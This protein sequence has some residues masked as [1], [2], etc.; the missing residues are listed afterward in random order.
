MRKLICV[1]FVLISVFSLF[2]NAELF[3]Q[4]SSEVQ[5]LQ[6]LFRRAGLA[7]PELIYPVASDNLLKLMEYSD[8]KNKLETDDLKDYQVLYDRFNGNNLFTVNE[9]FKFDADVSVAPVA[10]YNYGKH[11]DNPMTDLI[12]GLNE[13]LPF[14]IGIAK[15]ELGKCF[16]GR[17]EYDYTKIFSKYYSDGFILNLPKGSRNMTGPYSTYLSVG[18]NV[19]NLFAGRVRASSGNGI[20]GN[21]AIGDNFIYR[22]TV[23]FGLYT[24][25]FVYELFINTFSN[26]PENSNSYFT[27]QLDASRPLVMIHKASYSILDNLSVGFYEGI[28]DYSTASPFD[29]RI[30]NPFVLFHNLITYHYSTNNFFGFETDFS[31]KNGHSFHSQVLF[32]QIN[33]GPGEDYKNEPNSF[34]ILFNYQ[35]AARLNENPFIG[36][37]EFAYTNPWLYMKTEKFPYGTV[38]N[39][40]Y[41]DLDLMVGNFHTNNEFDAN[42]IGYKFG[43]NTLAFDLGAEYEIKNNKLGAD[44]LLKFSGDTG[45]YGID[46]AIGD[47]ERT[48]KAVSPFCYVT[49]HENQCLIQLKLSDEATLFDNALSVNLTVGLQ[50]YINYGCVKGDNPFNVQFSLGAKVDPLKIIERVKI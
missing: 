43:P 2:A 23:K 31:L 10:Y 24:F 9:M 37:F 34:G 29:P 39:Y 25:P 40:D 4:S 28:L 48:R 12:V 36:Y 7:M 46:Y 15:L 3:E 14:L 38:E 17:F 13:R 30:I 27:P 49:D 1:L 26:E 33:L 22:D 44:L 6:Y 11:F 18:N 16:F 35:Y 5:K 50:K 45:M 47:S 42:Y 32:D 41:H 20:S 8:L 21:L 19:F